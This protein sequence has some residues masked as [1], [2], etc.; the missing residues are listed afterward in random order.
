MSK[1]SYKE[2]EIGGNDFG[3]YTSDVL[4][5]TIWPD[6]DG[7]VTIN[8]THGPPIELNV[9]ELRTLRDWLDDNLPPRSHLKRL[10][11]AK[12]RLARLEARI[13][14]ARVA[15][16]NAYALVQTLE[17]EALCLEQEIEGIE[18]GDIT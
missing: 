6:D 11:I 8:L 7:F 17:G 10:D 3:E 2:L 9:E 13:K 15:E 16:S 18:K 4:S 12:Q 1:I 5:I 14:D